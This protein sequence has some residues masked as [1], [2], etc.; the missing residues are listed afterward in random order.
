MNKSIIDYYTNYREIIQKVDFYQNAFL[1]IEI[2]DF[3]ECIKNLKL[4][5]NQIRLLFNQGN[6][7]TQRYLTVLIKDPKNQL[8]DEL[9]QTI[10]T[11]IGIMKK[12][13]IFD[14]EATC[15]IATALVEYYE[16]HEDVDDY[17]EKYTK[18]LFN[19][20]YHEHYLYSSTHD[21]KAFQMYVKILQYQDLYKESTNEYFRYRINWSL[22]NCFRNYLTSM[23]PTDLSIV[24]QKLSEIIDFW[25]DD[26]IRSM[27]CNH[28]D[29]TH[30]MNNLIS[31]TLQEMIHNHAK[32]NMHD[33]EFAFEFAK[34]QYDEVL[35]SATNQYIRVDFFVNYNYFAY[36][37]GKIDV[38]E[39]FHQ[40]NNFYIENFRK[41]E[42]IIGQNKAVSKF[43]ETIITRLAPLLLECAGNCGFTSFELKNFRES[44]LDDIYEYFTNLETGKSD[45]SINDLI[46]LTLLDI[47][48]YYEGSPKILEEILNM[49]VYKHIPTLVHSIMV[50]RLAVLILE[51]YIVVHPEFFVGLEDTTSVE[52]V[53]EKKNLIVHFIETASIAHDIGKITCLNII[54]VCTRKLSDIEFSDIKRHTTK[55]YSILASIPA[56]K[57]YAYVAKY[58]HLFYNEQGGYPHYDNDLSPEMKNI[59]SIVTVCDGMD[60]ATDLLGRSYQQTKTFEE[61]MNELI[62]EKGTRYDPV[63]VDFINNNE[64]LKAELKNFVTNKREKIYW[65]A[66]L[67]WNPNKRIRNE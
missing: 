44:I 12:Y 26:S 54:K 59:V 24:L 48:K 43:V 34:K 25:T 66:Y 15:S 17:I 42:E 51:S 10:N 64:S 18:S 53:L 65:E 27:T 7:L 13:G 5:A 36:K 37:I 31:F 50:S 55:G 30:R 6:T 63:L 20:A 52:D 33:Y 35:K 21:Y 40:L 29:F 28:F 19:E 49:T 45:D 23:H 11:Q 56:F 9:C 60:A 58:H 62:E 39:L 22:D 3:E 1:T 16:D 61:L 47:L 32:G 67:H 57:K 2:K 4:M 38:K 8:N 46:K 41:N 14:Y